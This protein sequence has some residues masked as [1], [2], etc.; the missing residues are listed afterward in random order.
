MVLK[1]NTQCTPRGCA[2]T[3]VM[4]AEVVSVKKLPLSLISVL[5]HLNGQRSAFRYL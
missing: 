1:H 5:S 4:D 3:L 2:A